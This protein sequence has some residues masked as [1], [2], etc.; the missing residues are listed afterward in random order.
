[1]FYP[2]INQS[3]SNNFVFSH[4]YLLYEVYHYRAPKNNRQICWTIHKFTRMVP[5]DIPM[6]GISLSILCHFLFTFFILY[7]FHI[8]ISLYLKATWLLFEGS[9]RIMKWHN[10]SW[11]YHI[12]PI[13]TMYV[14]F[15]QC[16]IIDM[17]QTN[18]Q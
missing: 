8:R 9:C 6:V 14:Y 11:M 1:M 3:Y 17:E 16:Q 2:Y 10:L 13:H 7:P 18:P 4:F 15:F 5:Q 12:K